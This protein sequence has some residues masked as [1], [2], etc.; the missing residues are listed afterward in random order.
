LD[1]I[2]GTKFNSI[3]YE[4]TICKDFLSNKK[5]RPKSMVHCIMLTTIIFL[6]DLNVSSLG[7]RL[8]CKEAEHAKN[9]VMVFV[10]NVHS[11]LLLVG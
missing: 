2:K 7:E 10:D 3:R 4:K 6:K 8:F 9:I 11:F 1:T 5:D